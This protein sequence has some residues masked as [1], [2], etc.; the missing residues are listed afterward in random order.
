MLVIKPYSN[1]SSSVKSRSLLSY[2]IVLIIGEFSFLSLE[3]YLDEYSSLILISETIFLNSGSGF[4][5]NCVLGVVDL[6]GGGGGGDVGGEVDGGG[7][8]VYVSG[9][10]GVNAV[11]YDT[12]LLLRGLFIS[13]PISIS[14][15]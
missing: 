6:V 9:F 11:L 13:S 2:A 7:G 12:V 5:L 3:I 14:S 10:G 8:R 4:S 15:F 1:N